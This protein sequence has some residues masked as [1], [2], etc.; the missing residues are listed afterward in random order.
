[1]IKTPQDLKAYFISEVETFMLQKENL[2]ESFLLRF[3][4]N[5]PKNL[6]SEALDFVFNN[7][8]SELPTITEW[9]ISK[10]KDE[11]NDRLD[12]PT[13]KEYIQ[14]EILKI[15]DVIKRFYRRDWYSYDKLY[16]EVFE[17]KSI[18]NIVTKYLNEHSQLN[19]HSRL[20]F[21]RENTELRQLSSLIEAELE[22]MVLKLEY[23]RIENNPQ[24]VEKEEKGMISINYSSIDFKPT[25]NKTDTLWF[26]VGVLF[27]NG[28]MDKY[29]KE[30]IKGDKHG[31]KDEYTMPII[32]EEV[33]LPKAKK[34][35]LATFNDYPKDSK[36]ADK[37]IFNSI[38][39]TDLIISYLEDDGIEIAK[40]FLE[41]LPTR[42][43]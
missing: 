4:K 28:T 19:E 30:T 10:H 34:Y 8:I 33:G 37:N 32:A 31:I 9:L 22:I 24:N 25:P 12:P 21:P 20:P 43:I 38:D 18:D 6:I 13:K 42:T 5:Y 17:N 40:S 26:K 7:I 29:W 41:K 27:A 1:M 3:N 14:S 35:I 2:K 15:R 36:N 16:I 23:E 39:K 11:L